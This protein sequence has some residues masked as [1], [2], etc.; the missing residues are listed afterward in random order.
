MM[1]L[2]RTFVVDWKP[3]LTYAIFPCKTQL[4]SSNREVSD[5]MM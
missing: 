4:S 1:L 2:L 5:C 3:D